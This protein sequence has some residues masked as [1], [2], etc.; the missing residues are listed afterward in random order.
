LGGDEVEVFGVGRSPGR[1]PA[2]PIV[3]AHQGRRAVDDHRLGVRDPRLVIDPDGDT[4]RGQRVDPARTSTRRGP[5]CDQPDI[6]AALFSPDQR[7]DDPRSRLSTGK[8]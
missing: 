5:V 1:S 2:G 7:S 6:N 8:R 3:G 4:R